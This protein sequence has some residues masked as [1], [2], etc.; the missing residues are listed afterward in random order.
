MKSPVN[1][2]SVMYVTLKLWFDKSLSQSEAC[3]Q[4]PLTATYLGC[5]GHWE[6]VNSIMWHSNRSMTLFRLLSAG[7]ALLGFCTNLI[8]QQNAVFFYLF[9]FGILRFFP[10]DFI[11][12]AVRWCSSAGMSSVY[13][14][15]SCC[16]ANKDCCRLVWWM[17]LFCVVAAD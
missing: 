11:R 1:A 5:S 10:G 17:R 6:D 8:C 14:L 13:C 2:T 16:L 12:F 7:S 9:I 15:F 4:T 3:W